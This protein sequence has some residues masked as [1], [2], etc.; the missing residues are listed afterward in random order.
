MLHIQLIHSAFLKQQNVNKKGKETHNIPSRVVTSEST[1]L[2]V[3]VFFAAMNGLFPHHSLLGQTG[4]PHS[5]ILPLHQPFLFLF[6]LPLFV[7]LFLFSLPL[8]V[9]LF[10]FFLPL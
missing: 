3:Y 10:L 5:A 8:F 2:I 6:F 7:F 9:F 4:G 1:F